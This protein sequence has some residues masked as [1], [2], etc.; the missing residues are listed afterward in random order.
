MV[1]RSFLIGLAFGASLTI[2]AGAYLW[3]SPMA[4][5]ASTQVASITGREK[6]ADGVGVSGD[7]FFVARLQGKSKSASISYKKDFDKSHNYW[8]YAQQILP[9]AKTGNADAQFYLSRVISK[10]AE[11]NKMYFQ[12]KGRTLTL[13]EGLQFAVQRHLPMEV[14]Q[15]VYEKCH[16]FQESNVAELGSASDWLKKATAAGQPV[17]Q[18]TTAFNILTQGLQEDFAKAAGV[19][20]PNTEEVFES[21]SDPRELLRVAVQSKDPEVLF[22]IGEAQALLDPSNLDKNTNRLAWW[23]IACERGF[24][25]SA[26]ASWVENTCGGDPNCASI[27]S[28]TDRIRALAGDNWPSV[29]QRAQ[30]ISG[31]L[32]AGRWSELG[33][34]S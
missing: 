4:A 10:C 1:T 21:G 2:A 31:K 3:P 23:L 13:D 25:C 19:A 14:A 22:N 15:S 17:A 18:A 16:N 9:A 24:D 34:G 33:I 6:S 29:Q 26:S 8:E 20:N 12:R 30:E 27:N 28:S 11:D 32:D 5:R 7:A